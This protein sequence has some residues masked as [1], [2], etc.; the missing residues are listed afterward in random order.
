MDDQTKVKGFFF[1]K[2]YEII[3]RRVQTTW[4]LLVVDSLFLNQH[5]LKK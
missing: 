1:D 2:R 4:D 5:C 3:Y